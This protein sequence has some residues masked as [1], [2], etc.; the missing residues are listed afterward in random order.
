MS[1]KEDL[2][3]V[4]EDNSILVEIDSDH[5]KDPNSDIIFHLKTIEKVR[6]NVAHVFISLEVCEGRAD[7]HSSDNAIRH[8]ILGAL[9][10][11]NFSLETLMFEKDCPEYFSEVEAIANRIKSHLCLCTRI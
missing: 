8:P 3:V 10:F 7:H 6:M 1:F 9:K 5:L 2:M 11:A 4:L